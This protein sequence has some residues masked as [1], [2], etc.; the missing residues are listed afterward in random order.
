MPH[1]PEGQRHRNSPLRAVAE[2][3]FLC[4]QCWRQAERSGPKLYPY[5]V[6]R[7]LTSSHGGSGPGWHAQPRADAEARPQREHEL[8]PPGRRQACQCASGA[9]GRCPSTAAVWLGPPAPACCG[10]WQPRQTPTRRQRS[11]GRGRAQT[12]AAGPLRV[13]AASVCR[14]GKLR[15][16]A[17]ALVGGRAHGPRRGGPERAMLPGAW[18]PSL[19]DGQAPRHEQHSQHSTASACTAWPLASSWG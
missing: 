2:G 5:E 13:P 12:A 11:R 9:L 7:T 16:R 4:R 19:Q 1:L 18:V 15:P 17:D 8:P 10:P 14:R 6:S 3:E